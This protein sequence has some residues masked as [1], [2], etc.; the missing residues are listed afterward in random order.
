[1]LVADIPPLPLSPAPDPTAA[2]GLGGAQLSYLLF[3]IAA[4]AAV[5]SHGLPVV[6]PLL[7]VIGIVAVIVAY[8]MSRDA[9]G[10]VA[11]HFRWLIRTFWFSLLWAALGVLL[12]ITLIGIPVAWLVWLADSI[13][14]L[15]RVIRGFLLLQEGRP[16]P[17]M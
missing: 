2:H 11:T 7:G 17:G 3:G 6:A 14:V 12:F 15:Y 4:V 8:V 16:A 1:V 5:V 9:A 10:Y 13:W